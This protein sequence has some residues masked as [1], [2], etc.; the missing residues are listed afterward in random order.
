MGRVLLIT[1]RA[2]DQPGGPSARWRS[3]QRY[4]PEQGWEVDAL[5]APSHATSAEF[6]IGEA[7]GRAVARRAA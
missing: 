5:S 2:P 7:G 6:A 4:L 3:L 1:H